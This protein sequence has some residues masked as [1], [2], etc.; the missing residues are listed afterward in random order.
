MKEHSEVTFRILRFDPTMDH[1]PAFQDYKLAVKGALTVLEGLFE[2]LENQDGSLGMRYSCRSAVCGSCAMHINGAYRLACE[3][4]IRHLNSRVITIRPLAHLPIIKDL[5]VDMGPFFEKYK[6]IKPYLEASTSIPDKEFIQSP[7]KRKRLNEIIDCILCGACYASCTM[8]L[9]DP[10]YL[11]PAA[12]MKANRF[13]QDSRDEITR[14]RL[15][16]VNDENGVWR[17]HTIFNCQIAC[18]KNLNPT[19]S[20]AQL[21]QKVIINRLTGRL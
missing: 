18:P 1:A 8:T 4:Q 20:I 6:R 15:A 10:E 3:T 9:T 7:R 17:C 12:L 5:V 13:V 2:I 16:I 19:H 11:G 21:K 14:E